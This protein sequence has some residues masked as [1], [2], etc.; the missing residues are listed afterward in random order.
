VLKK[1]AR[2]TIFKKFDSVGDERRYFFKFESIAHVEKSPEMSAVQKKKK[3]TWERN[4]RIHGSRTFGITT[5]IRES[6]T[7]RG[8]QD[9]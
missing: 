5:E 6:R 1:L 4:V 7:S 2:M 3:A 9:P 8:V